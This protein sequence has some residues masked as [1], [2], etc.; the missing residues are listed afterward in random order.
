MNNSAINPNPAVLKFNRI[1]VVGETI[2][3]HAFSLS[4]RA[5]CPLC[6]HLSERTHSR[7]G[8]RIADLTWATFPVRIDVTCRKFFCDQPDCRRKVFVERLTN[9]A[10]WYARRTQRLSNLISRLGLVAGGQ[11]GR[12][13]AATLGLVISSGTVLRQVRR[14]DIGERLTPRVLGVDDWAFKKGTAYG[15]LLVDLERRTVVDLLSDRSPESLAQWLRQHPGVEIISRDRGGAYA[16]GAREGAPAAVQV[17]DRWHLLK[18]IFDALERTLQ[19]QHADLQNAARQ[20]IRDVDTAANIGDPR[21]AGGGQSDIIQP[22]QNRTHHSAAAERRRARFQQIHQM[23]SAGSSLRE[24]ARA[25]G[26]A[27]GTV[28]KYSRWEEFPAHLSAH[29]SRR[30]R[31]DPWAGYLRERLNNGRCTAVRLHQ[32]LMEQGF[33]GSVDAVQRYVAKIRQ[34]EGRPAGRARS[35]T[36]QATLGPSPRAATWLLLRSK[37]GV[38]DDSFDSRFRTRLYER[39]PIL[40]DAVVLVKQF[41]ML[42]R[43]RCLDELDPWRG[44]VA[45][46][47]DALP[48]IA[49]F[50]QGLEQDINAVRAAFTMQ[51]SNGQTEGHVNKLKMIKRRAYGRA[52]FD[53]LRAWMLAPT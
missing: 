14:N 28:R 44:E 26:L 24:I 25:T 53:L 4:P 22:I 47:R 1:E 8:R 31:L 39:C 35:P 3:I 45:R 19:H 12:R 13:V 11:A 21:A 5:E 6:G 40:R 16:E 20:A 2:I 50:S 17:A 42:I 15:T 52:S 23:Q 48:H 36:A 49:G 34:T 10:D 33:R 30:S 18:N 38:T 46:R 27:R 51:W 9:V 29:Q 41:W 43:D 32:E 7:Y 37:D